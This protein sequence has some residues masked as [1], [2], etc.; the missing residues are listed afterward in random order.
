MEKEKTISYYADKFIDN[1]RN[2][3]EGRYKSWE[4]CFKYFNKFDGQDYDKAALMLAFYLASWGMYRGSSF[5][6]QYT[7]IIHVDAV[8]T[9]FNAKYNKLRSALILNNEEISLLFSLIDELKKHYFRYNKAVKTNIKDYNDVSDTLISKILMGVIGNIPAYDRYVK[10]GLK[11]K[12][13]QQRMSENGYRQLLD[14]YYK[15]KEEIDFLCEKHTN[16]TPMKIIDMYFW[17]LGKEI[18]SKS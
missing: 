12:D 2:S 14:F 8:K 3:P 1:F 9:I 10:A 16:Y 7:Y 6:L 17:E 18:Y 15:N 5:L 4:H 13:L 11:K